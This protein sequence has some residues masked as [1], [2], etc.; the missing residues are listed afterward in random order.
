MYCLVCRSLLLLWF[1]LL[2]LLL[3]AAVPCLPPW[4]VVLSYYYCYYDT[5]TTINTTAVPHIFEH[6]QHPQLF[7]GNTD[8]QCR[9]SGG[10]LEQRGTA[11]QQ[12]SDEE[13]NYFR[14]CPGCTCTSVVES[15]CGSAKA[16]RPKNAMRPRNAVRSREDTP[17]TTF[18]SL[19][20]SHATKHSQALKEEAFE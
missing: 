15:P 16:K 10:H 17:P 5:T 8:K 6:K 19:I 2:L 4:G 1:V 11:Q 12:T 18:D 7:S 14:R 20:F 9:R 13:R 3:T